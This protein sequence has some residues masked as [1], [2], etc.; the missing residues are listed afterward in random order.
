MSLTEYLLRPLLR[1]SAARP[2]ITHYDDAAGSRIELSVATT[3]NWAAK[4][5]NWLVD[6]IDVEPGDDVV[7]DLPSHWQ[8]AGVLLGAWWCGAN[9]VRASD[10]A[11]IAFVAPGAGPTGAQATAIVALDPLGRGLGTPP[12]D[13]SLDY[14]NEARL[15][16]DDFSP[17]LPIPGDTPALQ[18][19]TVD[20]VLAAAKESSL[21]RE[22]RVLS[23]LDWTVP[24]GV[25]AGL[26]APLAAGAHL[27]QVTSA[28]RL[29]AHREAERTTVEL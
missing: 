11:R 3:A 19:S 27:V 1:S 15:A 13:G 28:A 18:G 2:L 8:T 20:E 7:V 17:L 25:L 14:L 21:S 12:T 26:V 29:D 24:D 4:T 22:D 23:T 5:A 6:E 16:G 10:D 9:V